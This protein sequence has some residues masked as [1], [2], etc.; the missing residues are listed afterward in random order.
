MSFNHCS[1]GTAFQPKHLQYYKGIITL[2]LL[3]AVST[4]H[5]ILHF[6]SHQC[7]ARVDVALDWYE[8]L[9][10]DNE[11]DP[12]V[13]DRALSGSL[14]FFMLLDGA[15]TLSPQG[16]CRRYSMLSRQICSIFEHWTGRRSGVASKRWFDDRGFT[17]VADYLRKGGQ[18]SYS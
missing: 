2:A 13:E 8:W 4:I 15:A 18:C 16:Q 1:P 3:P 17:R 12:T 14:L 10:G 6:L 5:P 7:A 11:I 9:R